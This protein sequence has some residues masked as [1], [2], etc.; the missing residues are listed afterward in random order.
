MSRHNEDESSKDSLFRQLKLFLH[1]SKTGHE[2]VHDPYVS[3]VDGDT[4]EDH[5]LLFLP[6]F[7]YL[8]IHGL[9]E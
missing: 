2:T 6:S 1:D 7:D 9:S 4:D 5:S 8:I 3:M